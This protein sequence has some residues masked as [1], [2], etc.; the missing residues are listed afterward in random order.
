M[1]FP[2]AD[3][4]KHERVECPAVANRLAILGDHDYRYEMIDCPIEC[5]LKLHRKDMEQHRYTYTAPH[6]EAVRMR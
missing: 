5:G 2:Y 1:R 6:V 4:E 3:K